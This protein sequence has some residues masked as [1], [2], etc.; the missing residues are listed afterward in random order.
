MS[1]A[2]YSIFCVI[3][4]ISPSV[5]GVA[6]GRFFS[7]FVSAIPTVIVA[8]SIEDM[9]DSK[10]RVWMIFL[11]AM[12]ANFGLCMGPIASAFIAACLGW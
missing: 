6:V 2:L 4:G 5:A 1:T 11:W 8:G 12:A 7:G 3:V 9:F 10:G